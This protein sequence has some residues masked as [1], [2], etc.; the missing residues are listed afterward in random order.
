LFRVPQ[1]P[2]EYRD[3]EVAR[4]TFRCDRDRQRDIAIT[5]AIQAQAR[6]HQV[7]VVPTEEAPPEAPKAPAV[8]VSGLDEDLAALRWDRIDLGAVLG[9]GPARIRAWLT[10]AEPV[11][12]PV[13]QW[14]GQL[15]AVHQ[16]NPP[17]PPATWE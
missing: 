4:R 13:R 6:G 17:P 14:L 16:A 12:Q 1:G 7:R 9:V 11:P 2:P 3:V 5:F 15:A 10:G 8:A